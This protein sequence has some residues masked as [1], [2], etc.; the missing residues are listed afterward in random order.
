[1][2]TSLTR[3]PHLPI[4]PGQPCFGPGFTRHSKKERWARTARRRWG[5][6]PIS[7]PPSAGARSTDMYPHAPVTNLAR[8]L[9]GNNAS[10]LDG[11]VVRT[12]GE[13]F[14]VRTTRGEYAARRAVS[15]LVEPA[16]G[17]VVLLAVTAWG[18]YYVLAVL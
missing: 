8:R 14:V 7:W 11:T 12:K 15:C 17:D 10:Q 5:T 18:T 16:C 6:I 3:T 2:Q 1:M 13:Q 4:S 9:E